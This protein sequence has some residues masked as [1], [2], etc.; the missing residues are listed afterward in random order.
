MLGNNIRIFRQKNKL[1]QLDLAKFLNVTQ[2]T[3]SNWENSVS[4]PT[5]DQ[6]EKICREYKVS[7]NELYG[8]DDELSKNIWVEQFRDI[9]LDEFEFLM[10]QL[11]EYRLE[12]NKK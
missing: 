4:K 6:V 11:K 1:T 3:I 8:F 2:N 10:N 9:T 5:V 12:K 7:L